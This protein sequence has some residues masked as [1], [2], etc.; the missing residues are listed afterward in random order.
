MLYWG[1]SPYNPYINLVKRIKSLLLQIDKKFLNSFYSKQYLYYLLRWTLRP[2]EISPIKRHGILASLCDKYGSDKGSLAIQSAT[3][4]WPPHLYDYW[5]E[6]QFFPLRSKVSKVLK[7]G[8]GTNNPKL[9]ST[10][11]LKANPG[12]SLRV[13]REFFPNAKVYGGDIDKQI[14]FEEQRISTYYVDQTNSASIQSM[15]E[16]IGF[17]KFDLIVDD[18]LHTFEA[19]STLLANCIGK[20]SD[21][22]VY[23]I[24]DIRVDD[25]MRKWKLFLKEK[26]EIRFKWIIFKGK[27]WR[28]PEVILVVWRPRLKSPNMT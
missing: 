24:E 8:I 5:Y 21:T 7:I 13:W 1:M 27:S 11:G 26:K 19:N 12:A 23:V 16:R 15:W 9:S 20:L 25:A 10:M 14:L 2:N 17:N 18:G 6:K 3:Y 22:G 28:F 4:P